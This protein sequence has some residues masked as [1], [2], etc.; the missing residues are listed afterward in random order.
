MTVAPRQVQEIL[1]EQFALTAQI[2]GLTGEYHRLLQKQAAASF[3]RQMTEDLEATEEPSE[4][5]ARTQA[6]EAAARMA[7]EACDQKIIDLE[8]QLNALA[9]ELAALR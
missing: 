2:S 3:T 5:A 7:A 4:E 8:Q 9:R 6:E 1:A